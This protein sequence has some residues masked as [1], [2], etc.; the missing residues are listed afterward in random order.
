M[1]SAQSSQARPASRSHCPKTRR[2]RPS[3][4]TSLSG[5]TPA[6]STFPKAALPAGQPDEHQ[7]RLGGQCKRPRGTAQAHIPPPK[8]AVEL[9]RSRARQ[10]PK[11]IAAAL[12]RRV[13]I[14]GHPTGATLSNLQRERPTERLGRGHTRGILHCVYFAASRWVLLRKM[15]VLRN[16]A[17]FFPQ[18]RLSLCLQRHSLD[19]A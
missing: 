14:F 12:G 15:A 8:R 17:V 11:E 19:F 7:S 6:T 18:H 9:L 10:Q 1:H 3:R 13:G 16:G 5:Q 4:P 2:V